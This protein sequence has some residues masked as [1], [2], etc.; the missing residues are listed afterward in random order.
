LLH[1]RRSSVRVPTGAQRYAAV[2]LR[3]SGFCQGAG[4]GAQCKVTGVRRI[5]ADVLPDTPVRWHHWRFRG[6][7]TPPQTPEEYMSRPRPTA[8]VRAPR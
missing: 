6:D 1:R 8:G 5:S 7:A 2:L 4:T 3:C